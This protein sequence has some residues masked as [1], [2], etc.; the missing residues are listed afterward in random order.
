M[1]AYVPE[2]CHEMH[3]K[4]HLVTVGGADGFQLW[5]CVLQ[6]LHVW[7]EI[8]LIFIWQESYARPVIRFYDSVR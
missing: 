6:S 7:V 4:F 2:V 1:S 3:W 8:T 5:C